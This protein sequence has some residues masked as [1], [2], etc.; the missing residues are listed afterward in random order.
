MIIFC[1]VPLIVAP[2]RFAEDCGIDITID[3]RTSA[4]A[5]N[6]TYFDSFGHLLKKQDRCPAGTMLG[7]CPEY[8]AFHQNS[9]ILIIRPRYGTTECMIPPPNGGG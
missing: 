2:A 6:R 3:T 1:A 7:H 8:I 4:K 5:A 9:A